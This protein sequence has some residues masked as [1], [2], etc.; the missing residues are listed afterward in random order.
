MPT[1]SPRSSSQTIAT[2]ER[3]VDVLL[4]F[5]RAEARTLGVTEISQQLGLSKAAVHRILTSLRSRDLVW[6]DEE[7]RRY[8]LGPAALA[9][10][11][12]Y[13]ARID[14][15]SAALPQLRRLAEAVGETATLSVRTGDSRT[16]IEQVTPA[17][18]IVMRVPMGSNFPLYAGASG[19][20]ILA[21][22]SEGEVDRILAGGMQFLT[23]NTPTDADAL[24]KELAEVRATG[25]ASSLGERQSGA[26][27][28]AVAVFDHS[29]APVAAIS[30]CGPAERFS[31][32]LDAAAELLP[33]ASARVSSALGHHGRRSRDDGAAPEPVAG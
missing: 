23:A 19:K 25:H 5:T 15:R 8:S 30:V 4:L 32:R 13:S 17:R 31:T 22:L 26:A 12:A 14:V 18:E 1:A 29:G 16:Y 9:L 27:S 24:K 33:E 2:V 28:V 6:L 21:H 3:A 11:S 7:E 10:G 20:A